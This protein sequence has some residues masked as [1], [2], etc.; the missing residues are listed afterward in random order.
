[1]KTENRVPASF[2]YGKV[3]Y[4]VTTNVHKFQ[5]AQRVLGEHK[6]AA[7]KLR[8]EAVEIQDDSL[9]NIAKFSA[10]DA[11]K[12]CG[13]PVF[14]EDAGLFV[15]AL[16]GFPGPYSAYV[17]RTLKPRGVLKQME[18]IANR[19]AYF[20][21]VIAF[22][23]PREEPICFTGKVEGKISLKERGALGFGY[24]PIFIPSKGDGRTFAEMT[25]EEKNRVSHRAEALEKFAK[26]YKSFD[27]RRF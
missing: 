19:A 10:V 11:V 5:E 21:S 7:A 15:E 14:V 9:E 24:D 26:W 18:N 20:K 16:G 17:Y 22:C 23:S 2:P 6:V 12:N 4:F 8:V 3:A 13:L 27:K 1:M 25:T